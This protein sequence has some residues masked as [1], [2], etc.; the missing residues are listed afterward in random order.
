MQH[1]HH[2]HRNHPISFVYAQQVASTSLNLP[3]SL[4]KLTAAAA[5]AAAAEAAAAHPATSPS[6]KL[7]QFAGTGNFLVG[8]AVESWQRATMAAGVAAQ[9]MNFYGTEGVGM[10]HRL[11]ALP[12]P[13]GLEMLALAGPKA[14]PTPQGMVAGEAAVRLLLTLKSVGL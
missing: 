6:R 9:L 4:R 10:R 5:A 12:A 14:L 13:G 8:A 11:G 2:I 3:R 1:T 7:Q